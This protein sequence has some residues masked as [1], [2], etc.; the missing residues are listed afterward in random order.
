MQALGA[1]GFRGL[2]ENKPTFTESIVPAVELMNDLLAGDQTQIELPEL[3][4]ASEAVPLQRKYRILSHYQELVR[5][6]I[7]SFSYVRGRTI[8]YDT[9][10]GFI[11]DC[12]GLRNP[13]LESDLRDLTG[14]DPEVIEFFGNDDEAVA[15]AGD[16]SNIIR[17]TLPMMRRK[18]ILEINAAFGCVGGIHRSVWCATRVASMLSVMPGVTVTVNHTGLGL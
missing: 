12:R 8:N 2:H 14:L 1:F 5:I 13:V 4:K 9:G 7:E 17:N 18:G 11:F 3:K 16:C 15:F 10:N 6:N